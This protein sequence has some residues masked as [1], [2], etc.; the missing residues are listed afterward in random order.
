MAINS[1][2]FFFW[3]LLLERLHGVEDAADEAFDDRPVVAGEVGAGEPDVGDQLVG[4]PVVTSMRL[5]LT[6][7]RL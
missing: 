4:L 1:A 6:F 5:P 3:L 7:A 2:T